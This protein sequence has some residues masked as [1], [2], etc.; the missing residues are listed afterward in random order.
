M[1]NQIMVEQAM[2]DHTARLQ[3]AAPAGARTGLARACP[4]CPASAHMGPNHR[5]MWAWTG[6]APG[7]EWAPYGH[8][9]N[10]PWLP[11]QTP[12]GARTGLSRAITGIHTG[13]QAALCPQRP[14]L[15]P[16]RPHTGSD[17]GLYGYQ[18]VRA[19]IGHHGHARTGPAQISVRTQIL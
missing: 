6:C 8:A 16:Y 18:F 13:W 4:V 1:Y 2:P 14:R 11:R 9:R 15:G 17:W 3:I 5:L 10:A 12:Q 7:S 19:T